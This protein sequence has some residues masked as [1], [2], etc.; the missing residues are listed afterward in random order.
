M[1]IGFNLFKDYAKIS[2]F[3]H[4]DT[5]LPK[6]YDILII[7]KLNT[8]KFCFFKLKFDNNHG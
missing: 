5:L 7:N 4:C 8:F 3:L 6:N 1:N 2:I